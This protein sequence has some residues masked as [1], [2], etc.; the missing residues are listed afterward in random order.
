M[1]TFYVSSDCGSSKWLQKQLQSEKFWDTSSGGALLYLL[2]EKNMEMHHKNCNF[3][4]LPP[5][6]LC[7]VSHF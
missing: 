3:L 2:Q 6:A 1:F 7:Q 5:P 4:L